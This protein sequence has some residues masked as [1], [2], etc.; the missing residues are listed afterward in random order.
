VINV[1][2]VAS[3]NSALY[4]VREGVTVVDPPY[5]LGLVEGPILVA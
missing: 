3:L 5:L 1:D 2:C 4:M